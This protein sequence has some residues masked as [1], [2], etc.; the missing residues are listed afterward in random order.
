[1]RVDDY[2]GGFSGCLYI[3]AVFWNLWSGFRSSGE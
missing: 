2:I 1:V 3:L